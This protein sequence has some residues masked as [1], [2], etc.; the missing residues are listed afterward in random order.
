MLSI[1]GYWI[2]RDEKGKKLRTMRDTSDHKPQLLKN[3][4]PSEN[5]SLKRETSDHKP[6]LLKNSRPGEDLSPKRG[7]LAQA[8]DQKSEVHLGGFQ[9]LWGDQYK[10]NLLLEN[11]IPTTEDQL[12]FNPEIEKSAKSNK[13]KAK[14]KRKQGAQPDSLTSRPGENPSLK[15]GY[16]VKI[17]WVFRL[18]E[19]FFA[20]ARVSHPSDK[21]SPRR[22][23]T[24]SILKKGDGVKPFIS[25]FHPKA[26][27]SSNPFS[28]HFFK[29]FLQAFQSILHSFIIA[30]THSTNMR[31]R[32]TANRDH[33]PPKKHKHGTSGQATPSYNRNKFTS[34]EREERYNT[35]LQWTFVP[36]RRVDLRRNEYPQ[37]LTRLY[38]LKWGT[39]ASPHDKFDPDVVRE[40]YANAYPPE[41]GG[42]LFEHK[43]WVRGKVIWY[44]RDYLNLML[45]N[46]YEVSEDSLDGYHQMV[47]QNSTLVHGFRIAETVVTLCLPRRSVSANVD[48]Q[49]KRI[50]WK[51]MT[52]LAQIWMIFCLHNIIPNSHVS[53]LPLFDCH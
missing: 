50:Y 10:S 32:S 35:L 6:H 27:K 24:I 41:D 42:G 2:E 36:E 43:S 28:S 26:P 4:R 52:T 20:Q 37:F 47:A 13:K 38:E 30:H 44:D 33:P 51:D 25:H 12:Q 5:L 39:F 45:N 22:E 48:G 53:S 9:Q 31:T 3:S 8:R 17:F 18:G 46:P 16:Q 11:D 1:P 34:L 15:R 7:S 23:G 19:I 14:A 49:P 29:P 40:F 21:F